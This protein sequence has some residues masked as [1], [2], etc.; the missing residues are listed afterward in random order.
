MLQSAR[1]I[2]TLGLVTSNRGPLVMIGGG[3]EEDNQAV[4]G[5]MMEAAGG[6]NVSVM[7]TM[8]IPASCSHLRWPGSGSSPLL[9]LTLCHQEYITRTCSYPI[10]QLR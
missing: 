9:T 7:C 10:M 3:L 1:L 6:E 5:R 4:W 8:Y 2:F